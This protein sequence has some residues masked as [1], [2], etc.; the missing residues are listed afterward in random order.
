MVETKADGWG[1]LRTDCFGLAWQVRVCLGLVP[2]VSRSRNAHRVGAAIPR[3]NHR[4]EGQKA[5]G[6]Q[7]VRNPARKRWNHERGRRSSTMASHSLRP[8][9]EIV[10][11][12]PQTVQDIFSIF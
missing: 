4:E 2:V 6:L 1:L 3:V 8:L 12:C 10:W 5:D 9:P 7:S 11:P